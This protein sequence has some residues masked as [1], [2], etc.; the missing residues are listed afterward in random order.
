MSCCQVWLSFIL[1]IYME[2]RGSNTGMIIAFE[3]RHE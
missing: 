2:L 1:Y 3:G